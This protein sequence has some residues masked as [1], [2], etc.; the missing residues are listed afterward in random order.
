MSRP[1]GRL[2]D[3]PTGG[4]RTGP[5]GRMAA[6]TTRLPSGC[7]IPGLVPTAADRRAQRGEAAIHRRKLGVGSHAHGHFPAKVKTSLPTNSAIAD[8]VGWG[9]RRKERGFTSN[10]R[11]S[12]RQLLLWTSGAVKPQLVT[13]KR[14]RRRRDM[15][16]A[17]VGAIQSVRNTSTDQ[18]VSSRQQ[19]V[20]QND[21]ASRSPRG[22]AHI[23]PAGSSEIASA[24]RQ[25]VV[26]WTASDNRQPHFIRARSSTFE[27][28]AHGAPASIGAPR[29]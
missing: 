25:F 3:T 4:G 5:G 20:G 27:V 13:G 29:A 26:T 24:G 21:Q 23:F 16:R 8:P 11:A 10:S 6:T 14:G 1:A 17:P 28:P 22:I 18:G 12:R 15:G 19:P 9:F 2:K 7:C